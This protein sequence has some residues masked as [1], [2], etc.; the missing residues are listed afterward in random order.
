MIYAILLRLLS[1]LHR[2]FD[3]PLNVGHLNIKA[4]F[5]SVDLRALWKTLQ[6]KSVLGILLDPT[7]SRAYRC[8]IRSAKNLSS[9]YQSKIK[10]DII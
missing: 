2:E 6:S 3:R 7:S 4:A 1:E 8:Q 9:R 5:D 10:Y